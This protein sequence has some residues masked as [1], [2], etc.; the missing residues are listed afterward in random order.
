[1]EEWKPPLRLHKVQQP[2]RKTG[3]EARSSWKCFWCCCGVFVLFFLWFGLVWFLYYLFI[4][5]RLKMLGNVPVNHKWLLR[6][7]WSSAKGPC[8]FAQTPE[9]NLHSSHAGLLSL[10]SGSFH[11]ELAWWFPAREGLQICFKDST[12]PWNCSDTSPLCFT[13]S[14]WILFILITLLAKVLSSFCFIQLL[15][16]SKHIKGRSCEVFNFF[17]QYLL[18]RGF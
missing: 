13:C 7:A 8:Y 12:K 4:F 10:S 1:M 5:N 14:P 18:I 6:T 3:F 15:F 17:L 11:V 16:N 9:S 2:R